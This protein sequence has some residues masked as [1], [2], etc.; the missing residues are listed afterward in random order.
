MGG[1]DGISSSGLRGLVFFFPW[2]DLG[3]GG[4]LG[5]LVVG[6][7]DGGEASEKGWTR[8]R[9]TRLYLAARARLEISRVKLGWS[10]SWAGSI[11]G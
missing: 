2:L 4:C 3:G 10:R 8:G 1:S 5:D 6:A 7:D 9:A 11:V